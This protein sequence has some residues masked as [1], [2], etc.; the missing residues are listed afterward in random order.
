MTDQMSQ[1]WFVKFHP[2][3]FSLDGVPRSRRPVQVDGDQTDTSTENNPCYS[4]QERANM[5]KLSKPSAENQLYQCV[6]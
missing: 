3:D 6:C 1:S 5:L 4:M 2:G